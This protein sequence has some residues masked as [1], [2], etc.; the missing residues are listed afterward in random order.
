MTSPHDSGAGSPAC[1]TPVGTRRRFFVTVTRMA[2]GLIGLG[3]AVPLFGYV[4]S[5]ALKRR[6]QSWVDVVGADKLS[7]GEPM[8]LECVLTIKDGYIETT[9]HKAVWAVKQADGQVTILSPM[10]THLG[11]G[12]HWDASDRKFK[13]PCHGSVY[14]VTG[15]VLGGPAPRPLD[16]LPTKTE[17]GRLLVMYK[18]FKSGVP[19]QVEI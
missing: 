17:E 8:Q 7:A 5:P 16:H 4:V 9:S 19:N 10:C 14:D 13:C 15:K 2:A 18:E 11:C 6:V 12:Y 1:E 3:L